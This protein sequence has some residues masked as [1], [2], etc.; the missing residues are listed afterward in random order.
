MKN[1][2]KKTNNC[3]LQI[4]KLKHVALQQSIHT[5]TINYQ[6]YAPNITP[7]LSKY[8]VLIGII[9]NNKIELKMQKN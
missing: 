1:L 8:K 6:P 9:N 5:Y 7:D 2:I 3:I 4:I